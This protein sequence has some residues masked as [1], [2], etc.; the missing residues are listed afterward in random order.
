MA[1]SFVSSTHHL[2]SSSSSSSSSF[3]IHHHHTQP[4]SRGGALFPVRLHKLLQD[5]TIKG[6][7]SDI[8]SWSYDG[9]SFKVHDKVRF[10]NEIMPSYFGTT[11][12]RSFQKNLNLWGF[13]TV[14]SSASR[15]LPGRPPRQMGE[16]YHS[17]FIR[18]YP[19]LMEHMKRVV[20]KNPKDGTDDKHQHHHHVPAPLPPST[21]ELL[22]RQ[23][24]SAIE[25]NQFL[26]AGPVSSPASGGKSSLGYMFGGL[27]G[28]SSGLSS[29]N[30]FIGF[31]AAGGSVPPM[32][33]ALP[34]PGTNEINATKNAAAVATSL[35]LGDVLSG[36]GG[37][38]PLLSG[39]S[40]VP[41]TTTN[42]QDRNRTTATTASTTNDRMKTDMLGSVMAAMCPAAELAAL[43][44]SSLTATKPDAAA[45][46]SAS[47]QHQRNRELTNAAALVLLSEA[48]NEANLQQQRRNSLLLQQTVLGALPAGT[49][50]VSR[51]L[52]YDVTNR[53][54]I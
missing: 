34:G 45:V 32:L 42:F 38:D 23:V 25:G 11:K 43:R 22:K 4:P 15:Y 6:P 31:G 40:G 5:E 33:R 2:S 21:P 35:L 3:D 46:L 7:H 12:Y 29:L 16:V 8:V 53:A 28:N 27:S 36:V 39:L 54:A 50:T 52:S 14:T 41:A 44:Q 51:R 18:E 1:P 20:V 19:V 49:T 24:S 13:K 10:A 37:Y 48:E 26:K 47:Q 17:C 30:P 9:R